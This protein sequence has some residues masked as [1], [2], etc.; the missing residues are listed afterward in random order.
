MVVDGC[1]AGATVSCRSA[2]GL[3]AQTVCDASGGYSPK[4]PAGKHCDTIKSL[5]GSTSTPRP[6]TFPPPP[7][8]LTTRSAPL[9]RVARNPLT[10][11]AT[12][13]FAFSWAAI[14]EWHG[15]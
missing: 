5:D 6:T 14:P 15:A 9:T 4:L 1:I 8:R 13:A 3:V 10:R 12:G 11:P 2:G 7:G